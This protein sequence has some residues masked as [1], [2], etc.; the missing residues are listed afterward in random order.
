MKN[1]ISIPVLLLFILGCGQQSG[2]D[3][4]G[5]TGGRING[6]GSVSGIPSDIPVATQLLGTWIDQ[7]GD[8]Y[9]LFH[10][11]KFNADGTAEVWFPSADG[12]IHRNAFYSI[13]IPNP[14][15][16]IVRSA[17]AL[18]FDGPFYFDSSGHLILVSLGYSTTYYRIR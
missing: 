5:A 2:N 18:Y 8:N 11:Y 9:Y 15:Y 17:D 1:I 12:M 6:Y 3:P 16:L 14:N 10:M 13:N 4:V 7:Y